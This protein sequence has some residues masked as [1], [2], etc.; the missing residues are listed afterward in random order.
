MK[1]C[2]WPS[3]TN[4]CGFEFCPKGY[5]GYT[6]FE[7]C[8][9]FYFC[10]DGKIDGDI[11]VCPKGTLFDEGYGICN[12]ASMVTC[13]SKPPTMAPTP[14]ATNPPTYARVAV[15]TPKEEVKPQAVESGG[16][17]SYTNARE[18]DAAPPPVTF[19]QPAK[20]QDDS[21]ILRFEPSDD[22]YV[23][24]EQPTT[25]YNDNYIVVDK[26]LRFDGLIRFYVQGV[27]GRKL[28]NVKLRL[29]VSNE[30]YFGGNFYACNA[31]WHEDVVVWDDVPSVI[32][33]TPLAV[34]KAAPKGDWIEVDVSG[35]VTK[36]GPVALRIISDSSD[37]VMYSSKENPN[38]NGPQL[39][40]GVDS[41]PLEEEKLA[42]VLNTLKI[43][44]TDDAFVFMTTANKNY[45]SHP[46]LK[47][48][49]DN[50]F[51]KSFLRFDFSRVNI[52]AID[53]AT[54]RLYATDS[55][56]SGGVF[57]KTSDANWSENVITWNDCPTADGVM[58][59]TLGEVEAGSWYELDITEAIT[60]SGPLSIAIL[61][62]HEDRVMYSSKDGLHS[63]E[64]ALS[65]KE[66]VPQGEVTELFPS[67]DATIT[68]QQRNTNFGS[69]NTLEI[70]ARDGMRNILLRFD[71][72]EI[73]QGEVSQAILQIYAINKEPAFGGTFVEV[74]NSNW[75]EQT[76]TWDNAPSADGKIL[77]S[78]MEI[79]GGSWYDVY[80]T[81]AVMGGASL[82]PP[83]YTKSS[84]LLLFE[85][86]TL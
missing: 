24:E 75:K 55:S 25:N 8:S 18:E 28:T 53:K 79:E 78:L 17:A 54:L 69:Q 30:S 13:N 29:F 27:K 16:V 47:V 32:S 74:M 21:I 37:N 39:L 71:A 45:G 43:G 64:I 7:T 82:S 12:W 50:G 49:Q 19:S 72:S 52:A 38:G 14:K 65:L 63:P 86:V 40:V 66:A 48:D 60:E 67:D 73:P 36:D 35:L 84:H 11:D 10:K 34:V 76:I 83:G 56:P 20:I 6:A 61:G 4:L 41:T 51:K 46:V 44:P 3:T 15:T 81:T 68:L 62:S 31:N 1:I 23:Q 58:I 5:T 80:V 59:G 26:N 70:D 42:V 57:I 85:S 9:K 77:G 33:Q 2:N 22:A